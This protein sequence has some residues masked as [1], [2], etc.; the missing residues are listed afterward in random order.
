MKAVEFFVFDFSF[1]VAMIAPWTLRMYTGF[2]LQVVCMSSM[3]GSVEPEV[4]ELFGI[5][6]AN[7][8]GYGKQVKVR[9]VSVNSLFQLEFEHQLSATVQGKRAACYDRLTH[10]ETI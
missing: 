10:C 3:R 7:Q 1:S 5:T 9:F 4:L 2:K 6:L 8:P